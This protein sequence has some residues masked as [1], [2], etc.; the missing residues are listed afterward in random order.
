MR[1]GGV[2]ID[3]SVLD[4]ITEVSIA[5]FE[6]LEKAW[7]SRNCA[8]VDMKMEFGISLKT[9][10]VLLADVIDNDSWRVW[11]SGDKRLMK[12]KQVYRNLTE[13]TDEAIVEIKKNYA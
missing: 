4:E 1:Y 8:L 7:S 3:S 13:V 11:P 9:K 5:C 6:I 10:K 12:D 2:L